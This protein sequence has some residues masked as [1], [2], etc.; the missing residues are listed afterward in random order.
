[1]A[2]SPGHGLG[3]DCAFVAARS[4]LL[5]AGAALALQASPPHIWWTVE[6]FRLRLPQS[7][8]SRGDPEVG[9]TT[10][11]STGQ[12]FGALRGVPAGW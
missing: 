9:S 4:S 12:S 1:M 6:P 5:A 7:A 11:H 2:P 3:R 8:C 10:S